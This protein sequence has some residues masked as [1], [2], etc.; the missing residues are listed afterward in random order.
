LWAELDINGSQG[1][2]R[3]DILFI[4]TQRSNGGGGGLRAAAAAGLAFI[5]LPVRCKT[6]YNII[7]PTGT[8]T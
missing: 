1:S 3:P 2:R 4:R 5:S 7:L 8:Y 6:Y